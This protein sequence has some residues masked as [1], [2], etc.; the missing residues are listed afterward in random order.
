MVKTR[1]VLREKSHPVHIPENSNLIMPLFD[2]LIHN[3]LLVYG[4]DCDL[5]FFLKS[6]LFSLFLF[7]T[8]LMFVW[9]AVCLR[10]CAV[11]RADGNSPVFSANRGR[12]TRRQVY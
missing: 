10:F 1:K 5:Q 9:N 7:S 3:L 11:K 4:F 2:A 12:V 6:D 8:M